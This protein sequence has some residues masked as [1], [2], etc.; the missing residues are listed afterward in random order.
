MWPS[1]AA[2]CRAEPPLW[3]GKQV[4]WS[5]ELRAHVWGEG[6]TRGA[7]VAQEVLD[8]GVHCRADVD[9]YCLAGRH[10]C[11]DAL[12]GG[13]ERAGEGEGRGED[14][15]RWRLGRAVGSCVR[16]CAA[17]GGWGTG[18]G[19][20]TSVARRSCQPQL[21]ANLKA[22]DRTSIGRRVH[23]HALI[24]ECLLHLP[25]RIGG[26]VSGGSSASAA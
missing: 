17:R 8:G 16:A 25:M 7:T 13:L 2:Q 26:V 23:V 5:C 14:D 10:R 15:W 3:G 21:P 11:V 9:A 19:G 22:G 20:S 4:G 6:V 18:A 24:G 1:F 12:C